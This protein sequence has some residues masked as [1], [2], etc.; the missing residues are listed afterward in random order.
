MRRIIQKYLLL[1]FSLALVLALTNCSSRKAKGSYEAAMKLEG[2]KK[3]SEA[4]KEFERVVKDDPKNEYAAKSLYELANIY[5]HQNL[6]DVKKEDAYRTAANDYLKVVNEFP[7]LP[8]AGKCAMEAGKL[9]QSLLVP[10]ILKEE[11]LK[12][13]VS[14]YQKV[15]AKF[16]SSPDAEP[17]M[18]MI[19]FI[20]ANELKQIDSAKTTYQNFLQKYP[21]SKLVASVKMEL[22][23]LG[24]SP[25]EILKKKNEQKGSGSSK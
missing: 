21:N 22:D 4:V 6:P 10:N 13:A 23:N 7:E 15:V 8:E 24:A 16:S 17:A 25:E 3:Y 18:F 14:L 9:Y 20:Q 5:G 11:S 1:F 2:E 19:G 12:N